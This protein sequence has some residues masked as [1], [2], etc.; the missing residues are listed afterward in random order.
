MQ[1]QIHR[2]KLPTFGRIFN[3]R[4]E[5]LVLF[6]FRYFEP[7][8]KQDDALTDQ[9]SFER[10][11]VPEK[12]SVLFLSTKAHRVLDTGAV[13]PAPVEDYDLPSGGE[14]FNVALSME[15]CFLPFG[16]RRE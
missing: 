6:L 16:R 3:T 15:L 4:E 9:K 12:L 7:V 1:F 5:A 11:T 10:W 8:L 2:A 14:L 13:I